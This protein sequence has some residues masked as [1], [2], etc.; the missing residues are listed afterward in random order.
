MAVIDDSEN[1]TTLLVGNEF[2][3]CIHWLGRWLDHTADLKG[4]QG[5]KRSNTVRNRATVSWS[6]N[7]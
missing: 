1:Q 2:S 5:A 7:P 4:F 3:P 6:F